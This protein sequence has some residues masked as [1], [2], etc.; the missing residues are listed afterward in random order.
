MIRFTPEFAAVGTLTA[1]TRTGVTRTVGLS[2][3]RAG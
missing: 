2:A 1:A 3:R